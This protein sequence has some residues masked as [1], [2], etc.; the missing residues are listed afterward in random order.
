MTQQ[1]EWTDRIII[2][3][4]KLDMS[5]GIYEQER[6][7]KQPVLVSVILTVCSNTNRQ[8]EQ[9]EE[10][11]SYE[12]IVRKIQ[13]LAKSRHF[14]LAERFAEDIAQICF[15]FNKTLQAEITILKTEILPETSAVGVKIRRFRDD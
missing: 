8:L 3:N 13:N 11:I 7:K 14:N 2:R 15:G 9:I 1:D 10:V 12:E 5:I 4:L 6:V